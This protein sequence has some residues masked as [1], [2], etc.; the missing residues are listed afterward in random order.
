MSLCFLLAAG[1]HGYEWLGFDA[2]S[3]QAGRHQGC[4]LHPLP[5]NE[6]RYADAVEHQ[7]TMYDKTVDIF[8]TL[9][10]DALLYLLPR[11]LPVRHGR[12]VHQCRPHDRSSAD[13]Y[14][15]SHC[16][17]EISLEPGPLYIADRH[18]SDGWCGGCFFQLVGN[19][20]EQCACRRWVSKAALLGRT[21][22]SWYW[23][24][25]SNCFRHVTQVWSKQRACCNASSSAFTWVMWRGAA[26]VGTTACS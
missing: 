10:K 20:V 5:H 22:A 7:K 8:S 3:D 2:A 1:C 11:C 4:L 6:R 12:R 26:P 23:K 25:S 18:Q 19:A 15:P 24:I 21:C 9:A 17:G 16:I 13:T 14:G